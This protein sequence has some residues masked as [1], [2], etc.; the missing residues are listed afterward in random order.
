MCPR[1]WRMVPRRL[2]RAV[3]AAYRPGQC[4]DKNPSEAWHLAADAAIGFVAAREYGQLTM[5]QVNALS[6]LGYATTTNATGRL[7]VRERD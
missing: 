1:H 3:W 6:E 2:Q 4:D 7:T 5:A